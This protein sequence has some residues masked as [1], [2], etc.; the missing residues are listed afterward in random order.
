MVIIEREPFANNYGPQSK[1]KPF[2]LRETDFYILKREKTSQILFHIFSQHS[3]YQP[4]K[5]N[6]NMY[7]VAYIFA[8]SISEILRLVNLYLN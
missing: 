6:R 5:I 8:E 3:K 4:E 1:N 2:R 7:S